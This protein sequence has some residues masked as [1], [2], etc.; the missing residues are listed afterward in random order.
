MKMAIC[1][2]GLYQFTN[3]N[4]KAYCERGATGKEVDAS[5]YAKLIHSN[6]PN[7]TDW[8]HSQFQDAADDAD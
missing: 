5:D 4:W 8:E 3:K 1:F 7:V 2:G 6:V